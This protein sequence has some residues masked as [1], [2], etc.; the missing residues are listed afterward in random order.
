MLERDHSISVII[1]GKPYIVVEDTD[2]ATIA[3]ILIRFGVYGETAS[4][5]GLPDALRIMEQDQ[6]LKQVAFREAVG[7][8]GLVSTMVGT[9]KH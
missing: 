3:Q 5:W 9:S 1:D 4:R 7:G 6:K 8:S 2:A